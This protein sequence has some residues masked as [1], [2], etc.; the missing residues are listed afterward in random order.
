MDAS[1]CDSPSRKG[2]QAGKLPK[3]LRS[4]E[5]AAELGRRSEKVAAALTPAFRKLKQGLDLLPRGANKAID[6]MKDVVESFLRT[7]GAAKVRRVLP[8][9]G[10]R[11]KFSAHTLAGKEA[12]RFRCHPQV[13]RITLRA[14]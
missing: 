3:Y 11:F 4:V 12:I 7:R 5:R 14:D 2:S 6:H 8:D 13:T 10:H 1:A 9:I